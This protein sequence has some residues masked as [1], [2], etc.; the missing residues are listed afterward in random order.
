M[1]EAK[2]VRQHVPQWQSRLEAKQQQQ[3]GKQSFT[4]KTFEDLSSEDKEALLKVVAIHLK[5]IEPS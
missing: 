3:A 1:A 2:R 5:L 4:G